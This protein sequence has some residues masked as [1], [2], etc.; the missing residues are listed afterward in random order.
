MS[1]VEAILPGLLQGALEGKESAPEQHR[2]GW[3]EEKTRSSACFLLRIPLQRIIPGTT[4]SIAGPSAGSFLRRG[5]GGEG[6]GVPALRRSGFPPFLD[7]PSW[8]FLKSRACREVPAVSAGSIADPFLLVRER[9]SGKQQESRDLGGFSPAQ[10]EPQLGGVRERRSPG[11]R[12]TAG[13]PGR[14]IPLF[15]R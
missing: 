15:I 6:H 7:R 2:L 4:S 1:G 8:R 12:T 10:E 14:N 5:G 3:D 13:H 9:L 11:L